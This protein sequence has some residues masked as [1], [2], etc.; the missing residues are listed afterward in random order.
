MGPDNHLEPQAFLTADFSVI[1]ACENKRKFQVVDPG[2]L[3]ADAHQ[4]YFIVIK[5]D[6]SLHVSEHDFVFHNPV[7]LVSINPD[8]YLLNNGPSRID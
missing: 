7:S 4:T 1:A 6:A 5:P 3:E 2:S 8:N